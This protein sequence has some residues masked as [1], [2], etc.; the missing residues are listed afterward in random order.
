VSTWQ[1]YRLANAIVPPGLAQVK[2]RLLTFDRF[3][4]R[5]RWQPG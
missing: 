5:V 3:E 2:Y 4:L 1:K